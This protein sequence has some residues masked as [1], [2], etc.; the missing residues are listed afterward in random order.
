LT[1][2]EPARRAPDP[3]PRPPGL[4]AV[5]LD[6]LREMMNIGSSSAAAA[7]SRMLGCPVAIEI[8]RLCPWPGPGPRFLR[9]HAALPVAYAA[10]PLTGDAP[11]T[12]LFLVRERDREALTASAACGLTR[13]AGAGSPVEGD[14]RF[15]EL[16]D[17]AAGVFLTAVH[18][19]SGVAAHHAPP[20]LAVA[21][22]GAV[23]ER[24]L[25]VARDVA[26]DPTIDPAGLGEG[27]GM[28][29]GFVVEAPLTVSRGPARV[30]LLLAPRPEGAVALAC[31]MA[32]ARALC[33]D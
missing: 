1:D 24:A 22:G 2:R 33:L 29:A 26:T 25:N 31:A 3:E 18:R 17:I 11:G 21:R 6:F 7:L 12:F 15:G 9:R 28:A 14:R 19:F 4:S 13:S 16:A 8:P 10:M 20:A 32:R 5:Q 30:H 27:L 23:L